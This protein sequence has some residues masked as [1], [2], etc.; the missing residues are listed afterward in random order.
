MM[1]WTRVVARK[2][3]AGYF[4]ES[5]AYRNCRLVRFR[6]EKR[7]TK[8]DLWVLPLSDL[9]VLSFTDK[10][11]RCLLPGRIAMTNLDSGLKSRDT[12]LLTKVHIVKTMV[13]YSNH[14]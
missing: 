9:I 7:K 6:G 14:V 13:F 10:I 12:T 11:K 1:T 3:D 4:F 8:K 2:S 5:R